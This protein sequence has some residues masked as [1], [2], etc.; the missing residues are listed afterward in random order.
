MVESTH[1]VT[2]HDSTVVKRYRSW[3]RGE[4]EREWHALTLLHRHCRGFAPEPISFVREG[5]A[6][7]T[8]TMSRLA[9]VPLGSNPLGAAQVVAVAEAVNRLHHALP[10]VE[11]AGLEERQWGPT[12]LLA[13][14]KSWCK[15]PTP[16]VSDLVA[17]AKAS[18][19][20]W[21]S[22]LAISDL[23]GDSPAPVFTLA[24]GNLGNFIWDGEQCRVVDFEDSGVSHAAFEVADFVEHVSVSLR[25]TINTDAFLASVGVAPSQQ[26][27][28]SNCRRLFAVFWLMMLLPG[29]PGHNRNPPGSVE[30]QAH[31]LL[32]LLAGP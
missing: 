1:D 27:T 21:L 6:P 19:V 7:P 8:I 12:Q 2:F 4:P 26:D 10:L 25:G 28:M 13:E 23:T 17:D 30:Q 22:A 11:L 24:D 32:A 15:E 29:N 18:G 14:L 16:A 5:D 3:D 31:H 9:G 20:A